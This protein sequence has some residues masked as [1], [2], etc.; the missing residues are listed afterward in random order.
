VG[1]L[2]QRYPDLLLC[3]LHRDVHARH[4]PGASHSPSP[5][6]WGE[7]LGSWV[8]AVGLRGRGS[9]RDQ[10]AWWGCIGPTGKINLF[11]A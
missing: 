2:V 5:S 8:S 11:V 1:E 9:G 4:P 6:R 3:P 7:T 10:K